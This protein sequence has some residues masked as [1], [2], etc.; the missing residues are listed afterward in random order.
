VFA[1]PSLPLFLESHHVNSGPWCYGLSE[2]VADWCACGVNVSLTAG[3]YASNSLSMIGMTVMGGS[4][5]IVGSA[6]PSLKMLVTLP[7][8]P[9]GG[10]KHGYRSL[11]DEEG[12]SVTVRH[13]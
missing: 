1:G 6:P 7:C 2:R 9:R 8:A 13:R 11:F 12:N 5:C 3:Q 10:I 4:C